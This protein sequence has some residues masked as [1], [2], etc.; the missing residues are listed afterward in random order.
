MGCLISKSSS[1]SESSDDQPPKVYSW[2]TRTP[3]DKDKYY[4]KNKHGIDNSVFR[5]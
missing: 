4:V 1:E 2:D 3:V 5:K